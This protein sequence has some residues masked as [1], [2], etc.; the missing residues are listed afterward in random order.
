MTKVIP[1]EEVSVLYKARDCLKFKT[2]F[3]NGKNTSLYGSIATGN[4][5]HLQIHDDLDFFTQLQQC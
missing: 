5:V 1:H 2:M 3:A 4:Y